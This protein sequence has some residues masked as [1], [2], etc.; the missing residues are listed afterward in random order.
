MVLVDCESVGAGIE[1]K[2]REGISVVRKLQVPVRLAP[3]AQGRLSIR[4]AIVRAVL[5]RD[6]RG[7]RLVQLRDFRSSLRRILP[8]GVLGIASMKRISRG[9]L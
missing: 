6:D 1:G 9:C 4:T 5:A 2:F 3:L 8:D 7:E